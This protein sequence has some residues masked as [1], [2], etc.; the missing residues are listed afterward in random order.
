MITLEQAEEIAENY[1]SNLLKRPILIIRSHKSG[2]VWAVAVRID[3]R[4]KEIYI[5]ED[6]KIIAVR[7]D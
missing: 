2:S 6:G 7:E 4:H 5:S 3:G 1:L